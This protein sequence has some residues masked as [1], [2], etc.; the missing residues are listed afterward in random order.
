L[1]SLPTCPKFWTKILFIYSGNPLVAKHAP[2][3]GGFVFKKDGNGKDWI[4]VAVQGTGASLWFPCKDSQ[5]DEPNYGANIKVAVPN[6]LINV[7]NGRLIGSHDL[8]MDIQDGIGRYKI[9]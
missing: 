4:G 6:G 7:S 8:K 3:D 9:L 2:W 5:S 1:I